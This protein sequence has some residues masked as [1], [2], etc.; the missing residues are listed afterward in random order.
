MNPSRRKDLQNTQPV[1]STHP[2]LWLDRFLEGWVDTE[3]PHVERDQGQGNAKRTPKQDL[4]DVVTTKLKLDVD[5]AAFVKE[6]RNAL[7]TPPPGKH[8]E[9]RVFRTL[10]RVV[11]GLGQGGVLENG[12]TLER[13]RGVPTL[14]GSALKGIAAAT[15]HQLIADE[16]W[17]KAGSPTGTPGESAATLF[18]TTD[19]AGCVHFLDA[20]WLPEEGTRDNGLHAD[21]ITVHNMPYYQGDFD[22]QS[23]PDGMADPIPVPFVSATGR[24]LVVVEC[25]AANQEWARSA[26]SLLEHGLELLGIGAK[27]NAGYGRLAVDKEMTEHIRQ[28]IQREIDDRREANLMSSA[29][30]EKAVGRALEVAALNPRVVLEIIQGLCASQTGDAH[31]R[32]RETYQNRFPDI[33]EW[34]AST[35]AESAFRTALVQALSAHASWGPALRDG[36]TIN[37]LQLGATKLKEYGATLGMHAA[38]ASHE[39]TSESSPENDETLYPGC[40]LHKLCPEDQSL[41]R[42]MRSDDGT[43]HLA[44]IEAVVDN[45][46]QHTEDFR[47]RLS[48]LLEMWN[49]RGQRKQTSSLSKGDRQKLKTLRE[50][51]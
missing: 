27:T 1:E 15:A 40:P 24:F 30:P 11:I 10:G 19:K 17:R 12:I 36:Q 44:T 4:V 34:P 16:R 47:K 6:R 49:A 50:K 3:A 5:H 43:F 18:G 32:L 45:G 28:E 39:N 37:D 13:T 20:L 31:T 46:A 7:L 2:G 35:L 51:L 22:G 25:D 42:R 33:R 9:W 14:P 23:A 48:R 29:S 26:L 8:Q 21:V 41:I 38:Q